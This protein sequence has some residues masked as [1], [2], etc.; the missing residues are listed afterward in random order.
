MSKYQV[1]V[2]KKVAFLQ[3]IVDDFCN[4]ALISFEG[5]LHQVDFGNFPDAIFEPTDILKRNTLQPV[6]DF[7]IFPS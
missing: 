1:Q 7:V 4:N 3:A 2:L 5:D 6:K